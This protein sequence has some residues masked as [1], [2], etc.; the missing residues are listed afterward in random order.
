M[1]FIDYSFL[2]VRRSQT[3]NSILNLLF[4]YVY[5][6]SEMDVVVQPSSVPI[7]TKNM[8]GLN[9]GSLLDSS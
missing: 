1:S 7:S 9:L 5:S 2:S 8:F 3:K 4:S 6:V